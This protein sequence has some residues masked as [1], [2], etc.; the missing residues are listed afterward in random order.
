VQRVVVRDR[1]VVQSSP[2]IKTI[3]HSS[4]LLLTS[5]VQRVRCSSDRGSQPQA[6]AATHRI[7]S[8]ADLRG[9]VFLYASTFVFF[10]RGGVDLF[11]DVRPCFIST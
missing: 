6:S 9:R 8:G 7:P 5:V 3:F 1:A 11:F 2:F 4:R 10:K